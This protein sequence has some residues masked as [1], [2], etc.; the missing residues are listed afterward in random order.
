M[1][2]SCGGA[3]N[4]VTKRKI[5]NLLNAKPHVKTVE[6]IQ[7]THAQ[8]ANMS[9]TRFMRCQFIVGTSND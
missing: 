9:T 2:E 8:N 7:H 4:A 6:V 3:A 5:M 1:I